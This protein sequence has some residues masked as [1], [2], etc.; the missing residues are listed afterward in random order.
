MFKTRRALRIPSFAAVAALAACGGPETEPVDDNTIENTSLWISAQPMGTDFDEEI[1]VTLLSER[2]S[3]IFYT[4]DG[5][6]PTGDDAILYEGPLTLAEDTLLMFVAVDGNGVWSKPH[7][8][9]YQKNVILNPRPLDY[10][11]WYDKTILYYEPGYTDPYQDETLVIESM[12]MAPVRISRISVSSNPDAPSFWE[13]GVFEILTPVDGVVQLAPREKLSIT[14]R[15]YTTETI[16][17]AAIRIESNDER[18]RD[19]VSHIPLW[20]R[21]DK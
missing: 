15:Y 14:V 13:P 4:L 2:P 9:L 10:S 6:P 3:Q 19:G 1:A 8:E 16:R 7:K 12:G 17:S 21:L 20:G 5:S 18:T 11:L